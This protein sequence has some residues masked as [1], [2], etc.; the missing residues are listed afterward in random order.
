MV[1]RR[2]ARIVKRDFRFDSS[3]SAMIESLGWKSLSDRRLDYRRKLFNKFIT[4]DLREEVV[5]I[6]IPV[7]SVRNLRD[8]TKKHYREIVA[9]TDSYIL[10]FFP[11][12]VREANNSVG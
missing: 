5:D 8:K 4:T 1:Q 10:S 9:K 7:S 3:V 6:V 11:R 12:G 2:A